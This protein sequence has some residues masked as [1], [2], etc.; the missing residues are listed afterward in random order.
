MQGIIAYP[1][2][3]KVP[4]HVDLALVATPA[5]T[6]PQ[7]V[8]ECGKAGVSGVIISSAGFRE[9]GNDGVALEE[10]ILRHQKTYGIRVIG[11]NSIGI[12]RPKINLFATFADKRANPGRI[13]FISQSAALCASA[14]DWA[15]E[16]QI[17]LSAVVSTGSMLDVDLSD[18]IDFF[19]T[20]AQTKSIVLYIESVKNA[21][22][23]ISA[24][25]NFARTKPIIVVKAGRFQETVVQTV[26][27]SGFLAGED[28]V[29]E[30]AFRRAGIVRV[31]TMRDLF[32][33]AGAL[34][35]QSRPGGPNLTII[36]NAGGPAIM[37]SDCLIARGGKLSPLSKETAHV[38]SQAL[39]SYCSL[40]NPVDI[41][42]EANPRRFQTVINACLE[43]PNSNGFLIIYAPQAS[44]SPKDIAR[45]AVK[46]VKRTTK[47]VLVCLIGE[48]K[49]CR[50]ARRILQ[51]HGVPS[52]D[53]PE[54]AVSTFMYMY[55]YTQNLELL[56]QTPQDLPIEAVNLDL[57]REKLGN[58]SEGGRNVLTLPE[59]FCFLDAY[60]IPTVRTLTA[61]T[62]EEA[63]HAASVV[64]YPIVMKALS[65]EFTH[66][67]DVQGVVLNVCSSQQVPT[68]FQELSDNVKKA[69]ANAHFQGVIVQPMIAERK[70]ELLIG[71]KKD[72]QFG[73][74]ILFGAGGID[75][76]LLND[77]SIGFPAL[78]QVLARRLVESTSIYK[79]GLSKEHPL[80]TRVLEEVLVKFSRMIMDFPEIKEVDINPLI[81]SKEAAVAVDARIIIDENQLTL[82]KPIQENLAIAPYPSEYVADCKLMNGTSVLLRPIMPEDEIRFNDFLKSLSEETMRF[83]FFEIFKEMSHET[84]TKYCNLDYDREVALIGEF[85]GQIRQ[86][87]GAVRLIVEPDGRKGEFAIMV[88]DQWQGVGLGSKFMDSLI[89]MAKDKKLEQIHGYVLAD[90]FRM[91]T[92]CYRKGFQSTLIDEDTVEVTLYLSPDSK[93]K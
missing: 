86:I 43:D 10:E 28:A 84:L 90:N 36:T 37:A 31:D 85:H 52:F 35:F 71:A 3:G 56:Y 80:F 18:L 82:G 79:R 30:A 24:A 77:V 66:K 88:G 9:S 65:P 81:L 55:K 17:G 11:P 45:L 50:A 54:Q 5:H 8:E 25:R 1:C 26:S 51:Q 34:A 42:E 64:G 76:N 60:R 70:Y 23:F 44:A 16:S 12:I 83:R 61:S 91:L 93:P 75:V 49:N 73:S 4:H 53:T 47:P 38:L 72:S 21:R 41:L 20:D 67:S 27:H 62:P 87:V 32:D 15:F 58:I 59:A 6:V 13:A 2:I 7:I 48:D 22:S 74:T 39:P 68:H 78:N 63:E 33:C 89:T 57:L 14:L 29:Y 40:A 46:S 69:N 92:L 19:G